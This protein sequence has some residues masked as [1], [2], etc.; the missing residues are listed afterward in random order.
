MSEPPF[1]TSPERAISEMDA[2]VGDDYP[3]SPGRQYVFLSPQTD[4][5]GAPQVL[6]GVIEEFADRYDPRRSV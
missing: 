3:A 6:L 1:G 5:S 4:L 2:A